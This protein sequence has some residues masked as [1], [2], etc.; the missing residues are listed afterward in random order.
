MDGVKACVSFGGGVQSTT[1]AW[2]VINKD[3]RIGRII[4]V[5]P[6]LFVFA[7][8]GD[9]PEE[10]YTHVERMKGVIEGAGL[11]FATV[12]RPGMGLGE[13]YLRWRDLKTAPKSLPF[14]VES[15]TT[16]MPLR[17]QCTHDFKVEPLRKKVRGWVGV[18]RG[19]KGE[20]LVEE[21][22]GISA[23]EAQREKVSTE[24]WRRFRH[25]LLE[26][27]WRRSHCHEYMESLGETAPRSACVFCPFHTASE[28]KRVS[29]DSAGF[30][31]AV[32]VELAAQE[33]HRAGTFKV[34]SVPYLHRSRVP[35][36]DVDFD[37]GQ[38]DLFGWNEECAGVCGV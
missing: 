10:V 31:R 13:Q 16:A 14:F 28:W 4:D 23:D 34:D 37:G 20:P 7:D 26:M 25:P 24:A 36:G 35:I 12:R 21:W 3:P 6:T 33:A 15:D 1:L 29:K 38:Q 8:V 18:P 9:E 30:D 32:A 22:L 2:L 19:Y 5:W 11:E 27:G 17:R